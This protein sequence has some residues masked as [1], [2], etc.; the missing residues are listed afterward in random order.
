MV[1]QLV[2]GDPV[3]HLKYTQTW[4]GGMLNCSEPIIEQYGGLGFTQ[5]TFVP[6]FGYFYEIQ[7]PSRFAFLNPCKIL[8]E[9]NYRNV[10]CRSSRHFF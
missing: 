4:T 6:D 8:Y 7:D 2:I 9:Q 1:F 3:Q 10:L 5:I